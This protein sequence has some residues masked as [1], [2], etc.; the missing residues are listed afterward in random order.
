MRVDDRKV[1]PVATPSLCAQEH[2]VRRLWQ[3]LAQCKG[4]RPCSDECRDCE[5]V[6]KDLPFVVVVVAVVE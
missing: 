4:R 1:W 3:A 5:A 2:L 6:E